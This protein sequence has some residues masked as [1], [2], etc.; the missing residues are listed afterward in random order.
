MTNFVLI[1][2]YLHFVTLQASKKSTHFTKM[3]FALFFL[4]FSLSVWIS[5]VNQFLK[6]V[7][8]LWKTIG[9]LLMKT[10][11]LA[12]LC[13][14]TNSYTALK[15]W[16]FRP[17]VLSIGFYFLFFFRPQHLEFHETSK[18]LSLSLHLFSYLPVLYL[19]KLS[20]RFL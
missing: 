9:L 5:V 2:N 7:S 20:K 8:F 17:V 19:Q 16:C 18:I 11:R 15:H 4:F 6:R 3:F 12:L 1:T 10:K 14:L 13:A